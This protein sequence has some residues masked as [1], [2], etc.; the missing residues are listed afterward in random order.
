M[1]TPWHFW[2][3]MPGSQPRWRGE[4]FVTGAL[5]HA[6]WFTSSPS[7]S[8]AEEQQVLDG[9]DGFEAQQ[10]AG[11][12]ALSSDSAAASTYSGG[13]T[14]CSLA[15]ANFSCVDIQQQLRQQ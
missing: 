5:P 11:S 10:L 2:A 14:P 3:W 6:V 8:A 15:H 9:L 7:C 1:D 4:F 13:V 12:P